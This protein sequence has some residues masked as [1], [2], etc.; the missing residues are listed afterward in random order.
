MRRNKVKI[1]MSLVVFIMILCIGNIANAANT[2]LGPGDVTI[3]SGK[4]VNISVGINGVETWSLKLSA[5]GG[6][7]SGKTEDAEAA[8]QEVCKNVMTASF[9]SNTPGTYRIS[10]SGTIAGSDLQ[11]KNVSKAI[12]ITVKS[13]NSSSN[14]G[15][16]SNS[17]G[18]SNNGGS[19][20][21]GGG[22]SASSISS[23]AELKM[24]TTSPDF[25]GFKSASEGPYKLT[26]ENNVTNLKVSVSKKDNGQK[27][28]ISG[29]KNL[30]VGTNKV[31][32]AVTSA[33][34]K[35]KKTYV[36]YVTR[37]ASEEN[38]EEQQPNK[39]DDE[40]VKLGLSAIILDEGYALT[41]EFSTEI[42]E[43]TLELK[44][45]LKEISI[46]AVPTLEDAKVEILGNK[47]LAE[48]E[49]I[50]TIKVTS[51]DGSQTI[52]YKIKVIKNTAKQVS[53]PLITR[54]KITPTPIDFNAYNEIN[55]Y[56]I[57]VI[58]LIVI[59]TL[60]GIISI[61]LEYSNAKLALVEGTDEDCNYYEN[62]NVS[63][64]YFN[65]GSTFVDEKQTTKR[66][67]RRGKHS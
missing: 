46:N 7:L 23:T 67:R 47:D 22:T 65:Y 66:G 6:S 15:G 30:D 56:S 49:N 32:V 25:K 9:V 41:P 33:D 57:A 48:G 51:A 20:N 58:V 18:N 34:G 61:L 11:K 53:V 4:S 37:K 10:L 28:A 35:N 8:G 45:D 39:P 5:S 2:T 31:T 19:S 43:Y 44:E 12:T 26:V 42:Y 29:N 60:I 63:K 38:P 27:V 16:T 50:V 40:Q 14:N 1:L 59:I 24:I 55:N 64:D 21:N 3:E 52:E 62:S 13:N 17:G 36:I 54:T